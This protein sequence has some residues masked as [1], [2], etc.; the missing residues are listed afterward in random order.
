MH[1]CGV[2][3]FYAMD[4]STIGHFNAE[5]M[6]ELARLQQGFLAQQAALESLE[7]RV[8]ELAV[9]NARVKAER[10]EL[11]KKLEL[12]SQHSLYYKERYELLQKS[13]FGKKSERREVNSSQTLLLPGFNDDTRPVP[14]AAKT[15]DVAGYTRRENS[16]EGTRKDRGSRFPE[17][18]RR[19]IVHLPPEECCCAKCGSENLHKIRKEVAEKLCCSRDPFYVTEYHRE[20]LGC[21]ICETMQPLPQLPEVFERTAADHTLVANM[22]VNKFHY[23]LPLY[24]QGQQFRDIGIEFSNDALIDWSMKGLDLLMPVY[25]ALVALV[26]RCRYLIADDTRLRAAVGP[27]KSKLPQYKQGTLWGLYGM[28]IDAVVYV[29]TS[30]RNHAGCKDVLKGFTGK[31]IVDGYDGFEHVGK[32]DGVTLVH[33]NNHARR[34][35][36]KSEGNDKARSHEALAFYR[37][38]YE[39][40]E[41]GKALSVEE[42]LALRQNEAV[43]IFDQFKEWLNRVSTVAHPKSALGKA[44][45]YVLRR[46]K[47]LSEYL[48]DG[49]LPIDTMALERAFRVIAVGRK[50]Y[51]HAAS[52][53]GA[54]GTAAAYSLINSCVLHDIDPFIYLCDV[55]ERVGRHPAAEIEKLFPHN[56]K[57]L[58]LEEAKK[59]Y[60]SPF[61]SRQASGEPSA[62]L[63]AAA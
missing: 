47:S 44:C 23:S 49:Y 52:E 13:F 9:E 18:L 42:R 56:W 37:A 35:F 32:N 45:A 2:V 25:T 62:V 16:S 61:S 12:A 33:C 50:N 59:R 17:N 14:P 3:E 27:V 20:V 10:D 28:E 4:A 31:L 29:F 63:V 1:E 41:R 43:P 55:L 38:L 57:L 7:A 60:G 36:V 39:I 15:R 6:A 46:W 54:V 40:E 58:Y 26:L 11:A 19:E 53:T 24:R 8:V 51:L 48:H 21:R 30:S 5:L 34:G 22:L